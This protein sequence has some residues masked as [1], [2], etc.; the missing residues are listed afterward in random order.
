MRSQV[1]QNRLLLSRIVAGVPGLVNTFETLD[2]FIE[3]CAAAGLPLPT[4]GAM[5]Q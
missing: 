1:I 2:E 4:T 3:D 5:V